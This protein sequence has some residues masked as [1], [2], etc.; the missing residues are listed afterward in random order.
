MTK[1]LARKV[2]PRSPFH[3]KSLP[4]IS[5]FH[6]LAT[7]HRTSR[8]A[9][10]ML[11]APLE[12]L[13]HLYYRFPLSS[14]GE[15]EYDGP[16]GVRVLRFNAH[17]L[18]FDMF[19][20]DVF[21]ENYEDETGVL[22]DALLPLGGCFYDIGSNWGMFSLYAASRGGAPKIHAFEPIPST[23]KDLSDS[24]AQAGLRERIQCHNV[25]LSDV[26][27]E[28]EF[29]LPL[30]SA[31]AQSD[32]GALIAPGARRVRVRTGRLDSLKLE[33]P[34]FM[35]IDAEWHEAA[36]LRGAEATVRAA[37][38]FIMLENKVSRGQPGQTFEPLRFLVRNGY[39]FFLPTLKRI[40]SEGDYLVNCGYQADTGRNQGIRKEDL[41]V[42]VPF[43][44]TMRV[45]LPWSV[46][47]FACHADRIGELCTKFEEIMLRSGI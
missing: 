16:T 18:A 44:P 15:L 35:K 42:L 8:K 29:Q 36:V 45:L 38:P 20:S 1:L 34:D 27:G 43:D 5:R 41:M 39:Q 46:N 12:K 6:R 14:Y 10:L 24:V 9:Q 33:K 26:D 31:S 2:T 28:T 7:R 47:L 23:F 4:F 3:L 22:L 17:N 11:N 21:A 13:F 32:P 19:Y 40:Y 37:K 30:H 25:A